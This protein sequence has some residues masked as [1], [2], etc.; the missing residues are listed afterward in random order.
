MNVAYISSS[1][2]TYTNKLPSFRKF[3]VDAKT[4]I[5]LIYNKYIEPKFFI[6][7]VTESPLIPFPELE[8]KS[9]FSTNSGS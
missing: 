3:V 6:I 7:N 5:P 1:L 9:N 4:M 2:T 8:L